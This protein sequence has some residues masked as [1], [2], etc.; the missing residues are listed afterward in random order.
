[1]SRRLRIEIA[2]G[3]Y[4]VINRGVDRVNIVRDDRDRKEWFRLFDR[5]ATRCGWRVFAVVLMSNHF[6]VFL[7]TP[8]PNLSTGMHGLESGYVTLFNKRHER[9]GPLFEGRFQSVLVESEGHAWSLSR[10]V[11]LNPC[12]AK[13]AAKPEAYHWSTYRFFLDPTGASE[14]LDWRTVLCEFSGTEAA[15]RIAYRRYV[16]SE[17]A[18][19]SGNPLDAAVDGL[20][21]GSDKFIAA[22]RYLIEDTELA[23][24]RL[25]RRV[26]LE[27]AIVIV[28]KSLQ[29]SVE[30]LQ[31]PG[32]QGNRA[33][34]I[35]GRRQ[36]FHCKRSR[37]NSVE[38]RVARSP[39]RSDVASLDRQVHWNSVGNVKR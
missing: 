13:I 20:L 7:K 19:T 6:H 11:H 32:R 22:H 27:S 12:R 16:E 34:E 8:E 17:M 31:L 4:H 15:A 28:A 21:L 2:G 26:T 10:Y 14:W 1:M 25:T 35:V 9:T 30:T 39:T 18:T 36:R 24:N 23:L 3:V 37:T 33:R 29:V 5:V 38:C